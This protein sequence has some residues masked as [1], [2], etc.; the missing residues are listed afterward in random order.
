MAERYLSAPRKSIYI[1]EDVAARLQA[2]K[3]EHQPK[4]II[5]DKKVRSLNFDGLC[6]CACVFW[7]WILHFQFS[8]IGLDCCPDWCGFG[9][10]GSVKY[11]HRSRWSHPYE[12]SRRRQNHISFGRGRNICN[13]RCFRQSYH[14]GTFFMW[15]KHEGFWWSCHVMIW[16]ICPFLVAMS[17]IPAWGI[18]CGRT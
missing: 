18:F 2:I 13:H 10:C 9:S 17:E 8:V 16:M 14:Q 1:I 15:K 7:K 3:D 12:L 11:L 4:E 6:R 5:L